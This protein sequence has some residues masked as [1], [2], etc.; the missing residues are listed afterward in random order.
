MVERP[1]FVSGD[2]EQDKEVPKTKMM[3]PISEL[4]EEEEEKREEGTTGEREREP[5]FTLADVDFEIR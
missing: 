5:L 4:R 2:E 1:K 3:E